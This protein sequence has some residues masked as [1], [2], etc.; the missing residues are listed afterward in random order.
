M[1]DGPRLAAKSGQAKQLVVFL[2]MITNLRCHRRIKTI[3]KVG[4]KST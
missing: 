4:Q 2:H 3:I 1:L